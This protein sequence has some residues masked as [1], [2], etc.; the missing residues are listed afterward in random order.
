[1]NIRPRYR[2]IILSVF[3]RKNAIKPIDTSHTQGAHHAR[4][5]VDQRGI[6]GEPRRADP[7]GSLHRFPNRQPQGV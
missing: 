1:M 6:E 3:I 5:G 7:L 2:Y 4:Q